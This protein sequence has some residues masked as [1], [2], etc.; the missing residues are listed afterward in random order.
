MCTLYIYIIYIYLCVTES[1][2]E[3]GKLIEHCKATTLQLKKN[4][5]NHM[6]IS[7]MI[8]LESLL[9]VIHLNIPQQCI[10][11]CVYLHLDQHRLAS[12]FCNIYQIDKRK[13]PC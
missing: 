10:K 5:E 13:L 2:A 6:R 11:M 3:E 12:T 8:L 4:K 9:F 1:L 7:K